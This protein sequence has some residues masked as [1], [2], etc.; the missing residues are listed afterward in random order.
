METLHTSFESGDFKR[1]LEPFTNDG[2]INK[3]EV[4]MTALRIVH[5]FCKQSKLPFCFDS[6]AKIERDVLSGK[7]L[8]VD[9]FV[10]EV[11]NG[12]ITLSVPGAN[13]EFTRALLAFVER[14]TEEFPVAIVAKEAVSEK[15]STVQERVMAL[16]KKKKKMAQQYIHR[17]LR[18][19]R[20]SVY[21]AIKK[22]E[23]KGYLE[24]TKKGGLNYLKLKLK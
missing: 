12:K 5:E 9:K 15:K 22:L 24:I 1:F 2:E 6:L 3:N 10:I 17:D 19:S 14:K 4:I 23:K 13:K 20:T 18:V 16:L 7:N 8:L 21:N 11:E